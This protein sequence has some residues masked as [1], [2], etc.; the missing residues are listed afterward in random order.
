[1]TDFKPRT[2]PH[3]IRVL[4]VRTIVGIADSWSGGQGA[5]LLRRLSSFSSVRLGS[6]AVRFTEYDHAVEA[7]P[8]QPSPPEKI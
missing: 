3:R 1:M 8:S 5:S 4:P 6:G 7:V 2:M